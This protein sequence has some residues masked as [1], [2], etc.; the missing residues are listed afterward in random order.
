MILRPVPTPGSL[1]PME[2][3]SPDRSASCDR[4]G[5]GRTNLSPFAALLSALFL[6]ALL[7][8]CAGE[9]SPGAADAAPPRFDPKAPV[10]EVS[11]EPACP[12]CDVVLEPVATL[13]GAEDSI[14][15]SAQAAFGA[16]EVARLG[17]GEFAVAAGVGGGRLLIYGPE[18]G[19]IERTIGSEGSGPGEL[20]GDLH[21]LVA[22]GDTALVVDESNA[23][24]TAF[25]PSGEATGSFR[26]PYRAQ[27][28][29]LLGD[30]HL[31]VHDRPAGTGEAETLFTVLDRAGGEV[32][33][34]GAA[35]PRYGEH[36]WWIVAPA[37][38][39]RGGGFWTAHVWKYE[40]YRWSGP[41]ELDRVLRVGSEGLATGEELTGEGIAARLEGMYTEKPP[42]P[43]LKQVREDGE[44]RLW[45]YAL[46]ADGEWAPGD[47][48]PSDPAWARDQLDTRMEVIDP[49]AGRLLARHR[50]DHPLGALCGSG[51]VY[52]IVE[53]AAGDTRAEVLRP[54]LGK[55]S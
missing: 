38:G 9:P 1:S 31:L 12:D 52:R 3:P 27:E 54:G 5:R 29:A 21:V 20:G 53:T 30:D 37:R 47:P 6:F 42:P 14:S 40:L 45:V 43:V 16:C 26:L 39:G 23:R 10:T 34:F 28:M 2:R 24:V 13:G 36:D 25:A 51:L 4:A 32:A 49:A 11:G 7:P 50:A 48:D 46:V 55:G 22:A 15:I 17:T 41:G 18:G 35:E 44:G 33:S 8:G 19:P